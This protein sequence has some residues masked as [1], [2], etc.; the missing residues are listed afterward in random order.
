MKSIATV[1]WQTLVVLALISGTTA[2]KVKFSVVG[3]GSKVSVK[4]GSTN[5]SLTKYNDNTPLYQSTIE[6]DDGSVSYKYVVDGVAESFT[7]TLATGVTTTHNEFFER[8]DTIKKIPQLPSIGKWNKSIGKGEL[9]DDSYI[10]TVHISGETSEKLFTTNGKVN[11]TTLDGLVF[12]LKDKVYGFK[13]A[14]C[15]PKNYEWNKFQFKVNLG[16][17]GIEGR[18]RLKFRDNNEDPTFLRQ[19]LYG[20]ILNAIGYPTI[21]SVKTRVYVNGRA[22]GYYILQEEAASESFARATFHGDGN[23]NLL[24]TDFA[25]LG[26]S[27][28]CST[29]ADFYL[30]DDNGNTNS[31]SSFKPTNSE[32]YDK[33]SI[34][35]LA[36]QFDKLNTKNDNEVNNFD[37]NWFDIDTFYKAIAMEY[38]TAHWDS[39][40]F[41]TSNFALY[42]DPTQSGSNNYKFYFICQ[43]WDGTF[44]VNVDREL[45]LYNDY[46]NVSYKKYLNRKW[47][48]QSSSPYR[49][50]FDKLLSTPK[51]QQRFEAILKEIVTKVFN[52]AVLSERVY[53][54]AERHR[55]SVAWSY[56]AS[57]KNPLRKG[58]KS[59]NNYWNINDFDKN[60][61]SSSRHGAEYGLLEFVYLRCKYLKKEFGW[62]IALGEKSEYKIPSDSGSSSGSSN[63]GSSSGSNS[64][65]KGNITP[66]GTC[67]PKNNN[68]VCKEGQCCSQYGYCGTTSEYCGSGCQTGFGK[69]NGVKTTTTIKSS[70][71]T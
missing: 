42:T 8:K 71:T 69:C 5:Y 54:L 38:L 26:Q 62:D 14:P 2:R 48:M 21:Q 27:F 50:A 65:S 52:P 53:A 31:F 22:V 70:L 20:D 32:R 60:L 39:Y 44:G 4:I 13:N 46:I 15:A 33:T 12:I 47:G 49:Y 36:Q 61:K 17:K 63:G 9:F 43:D 35:K 18:T 40:L 1:V 34:K 29:G 10:P 64:G 57:F 3:F 59:Q 7:R 45:V 19:D 68:Y 30:K 23:G 58:S 67:G 56:D 66:N 51:L 16:K 28:D 24:I 11:T 6:V 25:D 37:K 55:D 41:F